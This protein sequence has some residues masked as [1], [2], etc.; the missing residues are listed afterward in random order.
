MN[1]LDNVEVPSDKDINP[2]PR[3]ACVL[4]LDTSA[5]MGLP[6]QPGETLPIDE[7]NA[8]LRLFEE[9]LRN[10]TLAARRVEVAIV[11][12]GG[13]ARMLMDFTAAADLQMPSLMANGDT[14]MGTA[15]T[16]AIDALERRKAYY[17]QQSLAVFRP[18]IFTLTDGQPND[19]WQP[20]V[21]RIHQMDK[22][23]HFAFFAVGTDAA[24]MET[25]AKI[26]PPW[27]PPRMLRGLAFKELF[28][29]LS[30]SLGSSGVSGSRVEDK[31]VP[32]KPTDGW[33]QV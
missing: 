8:G 29:W 9:E 14:P 16:M 20:V 6:L 32:L 12:F 18:W 10:D 26:A 27:R 21:P 7:L 17:R 33:A 13:G 3:C 28:Q 11:T 5:S 19:D 24:D 15:I 31:N 1:R 30:D 4:V 22:D 23:R 2:D 25:L